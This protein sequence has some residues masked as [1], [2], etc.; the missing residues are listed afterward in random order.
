MSSNTYT[1]KID[2]DDSKIRDLEKRIM[3]IMGMNGTQRSGVASK[4]TSASKGGDTMTKNIA[5]LGIIAIGVGSLVTLVRKISGMIV[6]SSPMLKQM[7]KLLNFS[8]MLILRPIGDFIGFFLKPVIIFILRKFVLPWYKEMRKPMMQ[9]GLALGE[10]FVDRPLETAAEKGGFGIGGVH[11]MNILN[12]TYKKHLTAGAAQVGL[13]FDDIFATPG[14]FD[15]SM[16]DKWFKDNFS[17]DKL[18]TFSWTAFK[19][20]IS[21]FALEHLPKVDF[22]WFTNLL[23]KFSLEKLPKFNWTYLEAFLGLFGILKVPTFSWSYLTGGLDKLKEE[24]Q[25]F[26]D[27]ILGAVSNL[28]AMIPGIGSG[29]DGGGNTTNFIDLNMNGVDDLED[30]KNMLPHLGDIFAGNGN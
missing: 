20:L 17:I 30:L 28:I 13:W 11:I 1:L 16:V 18:P 4:M 15:F 8:V 19:G 24:V 25:K 26:I 10:Q 27:A 23:D 2:I 6:D 29:T 21:K 5:K 22:T 12:G 14:K 3:A 9:A 7:L